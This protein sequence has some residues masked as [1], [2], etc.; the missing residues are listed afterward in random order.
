M[1]FGSINNEKVIIVTQQQKILLYLCC[2]ELKN[3]KQK[4]GKYINFKRIN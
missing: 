4:H 3:K 1:K 2:T